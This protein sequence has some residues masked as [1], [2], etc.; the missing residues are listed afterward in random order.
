MT[1]DWK[2]TLRGE[3]FNETHIEQTDH[4][5]TLVIGLLRIDLRNASRMKAGI[6]KLAVK[7]NSL[8]P[9]L[10]E[11]EEAGPVGPEDLRDA[12]APLSDDAIV[13]FIGITGE[14]LLSGQDGPM[15]C[16]IHLRETIDRLAKKIE[17]GSV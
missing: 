11:G 17:A 4:F 13:A 9:A 14:I 12:M 10:E 16:A 1:D 3:G 6:T 5:M 8:V 2:A 15:G 7:V